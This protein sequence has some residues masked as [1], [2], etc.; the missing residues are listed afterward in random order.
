[1]TEEFINTMFSMSLFPKMTR[2]S[3]VTSHCAT[4]ID[5]IFTN[6]I[7]NNTTSGLLINDISD[8]LPVFTVYDI[9]HNK[10]HPESRIQTDEDRGINERTKR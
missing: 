4:F 8:H 3:R 2:P 7:E 10:N 9:K 6:D 5:N 1:M